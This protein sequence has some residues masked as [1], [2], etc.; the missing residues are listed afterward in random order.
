MSD[1][2]LDLTRLNYELEEEP[3]PVIAMKDYLDLRIDGINLN[4]IKDQSTEIPLWI[5]RILEESNIVSIRSDDIISPRSI[6]TIAHQEG[7]KRSLA[8]IDSLLYRRVRTEIGRL[9]KLG[10]AN[11]LRKLTSIEGSFNTILRL[12]YRK[13]LNLATIGKDKDSYQQTLTQEELFLTWNKVVG[14][15]SQDQGD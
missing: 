9:R 6:R 2:R 12:R 10:T 15:S 3:I 4:L 13:I 7:E 11:A 1:L 5:A 14:A 8:E